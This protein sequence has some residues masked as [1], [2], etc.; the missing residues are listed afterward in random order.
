MMD[1]KHAI[2]QIGGDGDDESSPEVWNL[3]SD[4]FSRLFLPFF[5]LV[6]SG[7]VEHLPRFSFLGY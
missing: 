1:R 3:E 5:F 4:I 2:Q 7:E 6:G